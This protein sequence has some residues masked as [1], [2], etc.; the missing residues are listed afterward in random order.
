MKAGE[1]MAGGLAKTSQ[2][3][4][5]KHLGVHGDCPY[6][7]DQKTSSDA[8]GSEMKKRKTKCCFLKVNMCFHHVQL[9]SASQ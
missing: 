1:K 8:G 2:T 9:G 3:P 4:R 7:G 5:R 6:K